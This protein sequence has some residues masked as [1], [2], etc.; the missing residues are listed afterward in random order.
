MARIDTLFIRIGLIYILAGMVFGIWMGISQSFEYAPVHAHANLAGF[1]LMA[2][3]GLIHRAWPALRQSPLST[4]HFWA[5]NVSIVIFVIG[6][7][8]AHSPAANDTVAIIGSLLILLSTLLFA[9][10]FYRGAE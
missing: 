10:I 4:W 8:I 1:V 7:Y 3:Y 9:V 5:H 2:L 6:I